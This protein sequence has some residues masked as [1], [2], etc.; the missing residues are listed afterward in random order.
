MA[1]IV[2]F[3]PKPSQFFAVLDGLIAVTAC[4]C[5][6]ISRSGHFRMED[7]NRRTNRLLYAHAG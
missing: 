7:D 6:S 2:G 4:P 5:A 3:Q 1:S